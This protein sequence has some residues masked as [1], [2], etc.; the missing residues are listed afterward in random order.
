MPRVLV[1]PLWVV[2]G[3]V[4]ALVCPVHALQADP[5]RQVED[6]VHHDEGWEEITYAAPAP[7]DLPR[8]SP[9]GRFETPHFP[10][11]FDGD[12]DVD[13]DDHAAFPPCM[14]GP[15]LLPTDT[16]PGHQAD[17][18]EVFDFEDD[19]DVDS[20]DWAGLLAV[21][22]QDPCAVSD[23]PPPIVETPYS[24]QMHLH[25]SFSEGSGSIDSHTHSARNLG[26]DVLWWSDHDGLIAVYNRA[27]T[28]SFEEGLSEPLHNNETWRLIRP[29]EITKLKWWYE[30]IFL[31]Q[32]NKFQIAT[33]TVTDARASDGIMSLLM[34]G[35]SS[36]TE[37]Q[38]FLYRFYAYRS[39]HKYPLA[40]NLSI[41]L[42]VFPDQV[43]DN[44]RAAVTLQLSY[45]PPYGGTPFSTYYLHYYLD[46]SPTASAYE[47]DGTYHIPVPY[48][49]GAWNDYHLH[50]TEDAIE[51]FPF[52]DGRDNGASRICMGVES[53]QD[54]HAIVYFDAFRINND[55]AGSE[56]FDIQRDM[57][58]AKAQQYP[59]MG[60]WQGVELG[61]DSHHLNEFSLG[62]PLPD[63]DQIA[64]ISGFIDEE[65]GLITPYGSYWGWVAWYLVDS[66]HARS[67]VVSYNHP[68]GTTEG[69]VPPSMSNE[70][71]RD[72]L[73]AN[74]GYGA[75]ILEV[76]YRARGGHNMNDHLWVW[77]E[78]AKQQLYFVGN[79]VSD[80]HGGPEA[81][82]S[83][84]ENNMISWIY[85]ASPSKEDLI[86]GLKRGRVFFG[87]IVLFDGEMDLTTPEGFVMGQIVVTDK[88]SEQVTFDIDG[89]AAGD[90]I[91]VMEYGAETQ[92]YT[93]TGAAFS[94]TKEVAIDP[95]EGTFV[96]LEVYDAT[97]YEKVFSNP[98]YFVRQLPAEGVSPFK[99][100]IDLGGIFSTALADF[101][102]TG[103]SFDAPP[104][105]D[106]LSISGVGQG[107]TIVLDCSAWGEPDQV[108]FV[109][110][111]GCWGW[112]GG[113]LTLYNMHGDGTIAITYW[114]SSSL[115][116]RANR[117]S[118]SIAVAPNDLQGEGDGVTPF[119]RLYRADTEDVSLTAPS[120]A[121]GCAF[122]YWKLDGTAQGAGLTELVVPDMVAEHVAVAFYADIPGD[123]EDDG[124]VDLKDFT[125]FQGCFSGDVS[126]PG[127]D[128]PSAE[129]LSMFD[130]ASPV[131]GD[132][133]LADYE[134][135]A[136]AFTGIL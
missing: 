125:A 20:E 74:E 55:Y 10:G 105:A 112:A 118:V 114:R 49:E 32:T 119:E 46:N 13:L 79:G 94:Q 73:L 134:E 12:G 117:P 85:A 103:A 60:Q 65:T 39:K 115:S 136:S 111:V 21:F 45:H 100:G 58:N 69:S 1:L 14:N 98:V 131:D 92:V 2:L 88:A 110:L 86:V 57:L 132:V 64:D 17:C 107:G 44:A 6:G 97:G 29:H 23:P 8:S 101:R 5:G 11:D 31:S 41:D 124:D 38:S 43:D 129:C 34:E 128:P 104:G 76:G 116:V 72:R 80:L 3:A 123:Q 24:V 87:D 18:L 22:G 102:L 53:R 4:L 89:L 96:R 27:H 9:V 133:D 25:G 68:F 28:F 67:G 54:G 59:D 95:T 33:A 16:P 40:A 121:G 83:A 99:A 126:E 90:T 108:E 51:G 120:D 15:G 30:D 62:T 93:A 19:D 130:L 63:Y 61:Y 50:I 127:F 82:W 42:S 56:V 135:F 77:D 75:D 47:Q 66:A 70:E 26:V 52:L 109:D 36:E 35:R 122:G 84:D 7:D 37:F 106:V 48:T 81:K 78:V 71:L 113:V 91:R